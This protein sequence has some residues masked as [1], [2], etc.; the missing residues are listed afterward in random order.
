MSSED[1][2]FQALE[3]IGK[4][5]FEEFE[6]NGEV[7]RKN[8]GYVVQVHGLTA[9]GKTVCANISGFQPYFYV[10]IPETLD[11]RQF[12]KDFKDAV[13]D[14][15]TNQNHKKQINISEA[16]FKTMYDFTN[17]KEINVF[18]L[19]SESK[20]IWQKLKNLFLDSHCEPIDFKVNNIANKFSVYEANIDPMLRLF[21]AR[22]ISPSGWIRLK[23]SMPIDSEDLVADH[24]VEVDVSDVG[25]EA[26]VAAAPFKIISW[27]IECMSSHGDFPVPKK[28]YRKVAR[29]VIEGKLTMEDIY[30][31]LPIALGC[32]DTKHFSKIY[33]KQPLIN[34]D[35][36]NKEDTKNKI[37]AVLKSTEKNEFKTDKL[38]AIFD[39][40]LPA[41]EGDQSIQIGMVMWIQGKPVE[42]WIY[43]L[44]TCDPVA[45][46]DDGVS[47]NTIPCRTE[48]QMYTAWLEKI[49]EINADILIGY[50]IFG[51][52]EKYVWDRMEELDMIERGDKKENDTLGTVLGNYL[53]RVKKEKIHL[54]EQKLSSAAMGDNKFYIM[55]MHGRLQIDLL[56]FVRRNYNLQS[57]SLDAVSSNFMAGELKGLEQL[58]DQKIKIISKSTKGL[59]VGRWVVIL[60]SENDKLSSKME[61]VGLTDKEILLR[62]EQSVDEI[63]ENGFPKFWCMV[64]DDVS[65][66]DIFRL[67]R[68]SATDRATVAKYCLQDCDLVMDLF[69]KLEVLRTGQA[70]ADVCCV[71]TGY[72]YMRGQG[73]KIESLIF[74][75]CKAEGRLIKVLPTQGFDE[76]VELGNE[77]DDSEAEKE[78]EEDSY[79]GAIVLP[80]KTGIYLDDPIAT[81]DFASLYPSTIIS[82]NISHDTLVWVKDFLPDG[83][84]VIKEGSDKYDNL[85]NLTYVNIEFDILKNDPLDDRKH[86]KKIKAGLRIARYVQLPNGQKGT[87]PKIL[88]KLLAAR[89]STRKLIET[90]KDDFKKSLLD[91]QQNAYKITANSLYGQLGSKVFKVGHVVLAASTTAY[92]RKQLMYAKSVVEELYIPAV[93]PA[94][95][96][97]KII[98][99]MKAASNERKLMK[100]SAAHLQAITPAGEEYLRSLSYRDLRTAQK[101]QQMLESSYFVDNNH[102]YNKWVKAGKPMSNDETK[103]TRCNATYVDGDTDSVFINFQVPAKGKE[104]LQPVKDLAIES[105]QVCTQS[106]KAPHD[107]EY[108]KIMWPF[109]LL[110]KKR[111]VGNKYE[112]D[113]EKPSMTSMGIVMKRRDNAPI[114]KVIYGGV[115]DRI[116][117]KHD[118]IGAFHFV[119]KVAK[120]L[121]DGKFGMTKLTITKSL[122]AEY[123]NPERIAHK[124]LADR[125][126]ARDPGNKPTSSERIGYVYIATPKGQKT[127]TLQGDRIETPAFIRANKLT[128]DYAYY[129]ECQ[130]S[131]PIAQVF[132]LVLEKLPGFKK[133]ELP[134]SLPEEKMV[135]KRQAV[136]ER[137]LFGD[138]LRDWKNTQ[139]GQMTIAA[140]FGSTP[141]PITIPTPVSTPKSTTVKTE[142]TGSPV[143]KQEEILSEK[144]VNKC[145]KCKKPGHNKSKCPI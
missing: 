7:R 96:K 109:C 84:V 27:D 112:D 73:I 106:L 42:K 90:E 10:E 63:K 123:A 67:H 133:H 113:L 28:D 22:G 89:K 20:S 77:D 16:K 6:I 36:L 124:V 15:F 102:G 82:E 114:V 110:S 145:S 19:C 121:I 80:P 69:N 68:G 18:Q 103:E 38:T 49:S 75:E 2:V 92:G 65:P 88:M 54:K 70:M 64:K 130:I 5:S 44:G 107:F 9:D 105:G 139:G 40:C 13:K 125:I 95:W 71:P 46:G 79:E 34:L 93:P 58:E 12:R 57:Y 111:Y 97:A 52:D 53:S 127:P 45:S 81:L 136:A 33:L 115:I 14:S 119:K 122:R 48:K 51:F 17:D 138:L 41:I 87:I 3:F 59:R 61:V 39:K 101:G 43:V 78:E 23:D 135:K 50:N 143:V 25:S 60:D 32:K 86:P 8:K 66:K 117:Q 118:V 100:G 91:C 116:L 132:A 142:K 29:E 35:K 140:L 137:L 141:A 134:A 4:D 11:T 37:Q 76:V 85:P 31:E 55:E 72:I 99:E 98:E 120:E 47:V 104:A 74:K 94:G 62:S 83:S 26:V 108:D 30:E 128:P 21:H 144:K 1:I 24:Y 126:A 129:I 131:K 56:P